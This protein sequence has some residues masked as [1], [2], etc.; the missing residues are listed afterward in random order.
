ML[1]RTTMDVLKYESESFDEYE[2]RLAL[3]FF[4]KN[5]IYIKDTPE[6]I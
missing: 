6:I 5:M 2:I 4:H 3:S 1:I